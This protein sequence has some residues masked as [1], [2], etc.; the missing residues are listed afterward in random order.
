MLHHRIIGTGTP[1]LILHGSTLDHRA[2]LDV[3]E[4][5][6]HGAGPWQRIYLDMPGHGKSPGRD[7]ICTQDDL[8]EAVLDFVD[9]FLPGQHFAIAGLSRGSYIAR[10]IVYRRPDQ[11]LGVALVVPGGHP[12]ADPSRLPTQVVLGEDPGLTET[13]DAAEARTMDLMFAARTWALLEKQRQLFAPAMDL[14]DAAQDARVSRAFEFSFACAEEEAVFDGPSLIVAGR[15][16]VM[17]GHLDAMDLMHRYRRATLAV[18]DGAGH[19]VTWERPEAFHV[20]VRDWLDRL[21]QAQPLV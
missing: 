3:M 9:A 21:A 4:P 1:V 12:S 8:L 7:D 16:D 14:F 20:L 11:V 6:F 13:L 17:S 2:M 18:L 15:Q 19:G 5:G 10:G